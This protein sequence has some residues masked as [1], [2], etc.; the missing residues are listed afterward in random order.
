MKIGSVTGHVVATT[1]DPGL[2]GHKL[3]IVSLLESDGREKDE[4]LVAIDTVGAGEGDRVLLVSGSSAKQC[5][6]NREVPIDA[7]VVA[8]VDTIEW[9]GENR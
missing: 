3:L 4:H 6:S 2:I 1:K 7:A 5:L 8:I 9:K